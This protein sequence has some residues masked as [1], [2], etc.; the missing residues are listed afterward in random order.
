MSNAF[1]AMWNAFWNDLPLILSGGF[2]LLLLVGFWRGMSIKP[3]PWSE[4]APERWWG[5]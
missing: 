1:S 2:L 3:R 4:R 5:G